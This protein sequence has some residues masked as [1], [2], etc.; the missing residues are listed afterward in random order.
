MHP[1]DAARLRVRDGEE[2]R[3]RSDVGEWVGIARSAPMKE[4]HVQTYWPETN[5]LI[6]RRF[7][8]VSGEPDYNAFVTIEPVT[9]TP[10][11]TPVLEET[12]ASAPHTE[13]A[14]APQ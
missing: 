12:P 5:C 14:L 10:G 6:T 3:L 7:D 13:P 8:P 11:T 4:R 2:V 9:T 1:A